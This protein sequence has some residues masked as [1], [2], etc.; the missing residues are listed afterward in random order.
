MTKTGTPG[1][2][3]DTRAGWRVRDNG[4]SRS[5]LRP[6]GYL[7]LGGD[8]HVQRDLATMLGAVTPEPGEL[9][10]VRVIP[11]SPADGIEIAGGWWRLATASETAS[12]PAP[13]VPR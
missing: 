8:Y 7:I 6:E 5:A 2:A 9:V 11:A 3:P 12:V 1:T 13:V 10:S 4:G